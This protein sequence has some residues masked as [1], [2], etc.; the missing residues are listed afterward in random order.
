ML[1]GDG[2]RLSKEIVMLSHPEPTMPYRSTFPAAPDHPI[3]RVAVASYL[4]R[5]A[6]RRTTRRGFCPS[7][8]EVAR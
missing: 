7:A 1:A 4:G 2:M 3:G 5:L 8:L 6:R